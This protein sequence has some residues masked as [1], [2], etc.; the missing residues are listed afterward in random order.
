MNIMGAQDMSCSKDCERIEN[1][2]DSLDSKKVLDDLHEFLVKE[3]N[4]QYGNKREY[5]LFRIR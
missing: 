3:I 1:Y 2:R 4:L 5:Y